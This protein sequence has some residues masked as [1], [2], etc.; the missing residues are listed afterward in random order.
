M[1]HRLEFDGKEHVSLDLNNFHINKLQL[2]ATHAIPN[3]FFPT[4][5][6]LIQQ[7]VI[8]AEDFISRTFP[9]EEVQQALP[10]L[11]RAMLSKQ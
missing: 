6:D 11:P 3:R 7:G 8:K 2:R 10:T 4:A 9:F 1:Q 5:L